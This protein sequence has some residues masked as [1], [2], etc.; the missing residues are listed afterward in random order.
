MVNRGHRKR[1]PF[2]GGRPPL[3]DFPGSV[4]YFYR[5]WWTWDWLGVLENVALVPWMSVY[6]RS[7][8]K[9]KFDSPSFSWIKHIL[10]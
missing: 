10:V 1:R 3:T 2:V 8:I 5:S 7:P 4:Q 9:S 6:G